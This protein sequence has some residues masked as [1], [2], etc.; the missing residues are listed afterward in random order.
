MARVSTKNLPCC[1]NIRFL[2]D[3]VISSVPFF[4]EFRDRLVRFSLKNFLEKITTSTILYIFRIFLCI[5]FLLIPF[6]SVPLSSHTR[7][8]PNINI[9]MFQI[10]VINSF[11]IFSVSSRYEERQRGTAKFPAKGIQISIDREGKKC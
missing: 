10:F 2:V 5:F 4:R 9:H 6:H 8:S 7:S 1:E 11:W 3:L